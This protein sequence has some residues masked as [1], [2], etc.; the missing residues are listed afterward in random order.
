MQFQHLLSPL[1]HRFNST[2]QRRRIKMKR[3][4]NFDAMHEFFGKNRKLNGKKKIGVEHAVH[5]RT[6]RFQSPYTRLRFVFVHSCQSP[7]AKLLV[8]ISI[9]FFTLFYLFI[10]NSQHIIY[11][12]FNFTKRSQSR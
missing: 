3:I 8:F 10:A 4:H 11:K 7:H 9:V 12:C 2:K 1:A 6:T 5:H